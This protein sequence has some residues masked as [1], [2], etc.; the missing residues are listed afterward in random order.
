MQSMRLAAA[1]F[2]SKGQFISEE[3][4]FDGSRVVLSSYTKHGYFQP[5]PEEYRPED[6]TWHKMPRGMRELSEPQTLQVK[7]AIT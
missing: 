3:T 1:F 6:G 7:V 4:E 2:G 5:F